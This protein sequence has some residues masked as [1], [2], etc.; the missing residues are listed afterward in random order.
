MLNSPPSILLV[1]AGQLGSRYLQGL[2]NVDRQLKITVVDPSSASLV[3]ARQ[4]LV[5]V[6]P[7]T[8]H[9]V[10]FTTSLDDAPKKLDLALVVTP[11]HCRADV[12]AAVSSRHQVSAWIL[13]KVL[14]QSV[15]QIV[16]IEK[17]FEGKSQ[18]WVNTPRRLMA[19]HQ[20]IKKQL[21]TSGSGSVQVQI[22][23][24]HWGLACNAIHFIDLVS[25]WIGAIVDGV[26]ASR[27]G[28]WHPSKRSGFQEVFGSLMVYYCDGSSIELS[29]DQS[30]APLRI[31]VETSEGIWLIE[32]AAGIATGPS[33]QEI[34]GQLVLQS[35]LTAPLVDQIISVG[36]CD[37]PCLADSAAQHRPLLHA[38]LQHWNGSQSRQDLA[39][40]I[41]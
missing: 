41:T 13:E 5:Q 29:C 35:V 23:G 34:A 9:Q 31:E 22:S 2:A 18:V 36:C 1:G 6:S 16:Q 39:V 38:L 11:A 20:A 37:L 27:L 17:A 8:A 30:D 28:G 40:P 25:W 14:A 19:W 4:R 15:Q 10:R 12:V 21:H 7:A 33:G 24:G 3:F 26:D 32:E